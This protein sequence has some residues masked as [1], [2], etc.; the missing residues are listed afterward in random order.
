MVTNV[1]MV[2][3]GCWGSLGPRSDSAGET[4]AERSNHRCRSSPLCEG[5]R[6]S[7]EL[8]VAARL[9]AFRRCLRSIL[10]AQSATRSDER[11]VGIECVHTCTSRWAL[12]PYKKHHSD[13]V[14]I[15]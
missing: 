9:R 10:S 15:Q 8:E 14:V 11:R 3:S 13:K 6:L 5:P 7:M 1:G 12:R 4:A 2:T